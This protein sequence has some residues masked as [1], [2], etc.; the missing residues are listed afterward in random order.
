MLK[1]PEKEWAG[2]G[3]KL[4]T[5]FV[6]K[7]KQNSMPSEQYVKEGQKIVHHQLA[8]GGYRLANLLQKVFKNNIKET[9]EPQLFLQN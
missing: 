4:A 7:I 5:D 9:A 3:Y 1:K 6:Y 2:E 8:L